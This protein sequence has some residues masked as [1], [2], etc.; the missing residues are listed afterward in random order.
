[1]IVNEDGPLDIFPIFK[2]KIGVRWDEESRPYA[3][4][5]FAKLFLCV[6]CLSIWVGLVFTIIIAIN[7]TIAFWL[8]IPFVFST[9][10]IFLETILIDK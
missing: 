8:S 4:N 9:V 6:W 5:K 3:I 2:Y 7:D 10:S 1:M